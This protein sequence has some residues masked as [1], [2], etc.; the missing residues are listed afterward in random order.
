MNGSRRILLALALPLLAS[1]AWFAMPKSD[2]RAE[3][4]GGLDVVMVSPRGDTEALHS[5][6]VVFS[7]TMIPLGGR[8]RGHDN[9]PLSIT[10]AVPGSFSW[11]GSRALS[12]IPQ[13]T[14]P[15]GTRLLCRIP[16]GTRSL[17]GKA[18]AADYAWEIIV[19]R[20]R[21]LRSV[22]GDKGLT[23][24]D[25]PLYLLFNA[26]P[27]PSAIDSVR[28]TGA[29]GPIPLRLIAPDSLA[30]A[31]LLPIGERREGAAR[32]LALAPASK[33]P[34]GQKFRLEIG[35]GIPFVTSDAPMRAPVTIGYETYGAPAPRSISADLSGFAIELAG[36][37]DPDALRGK[38]SFDP[39]V[40]ISHIRP[41]DATTFRIDADLQPGTDYA[42]RFSAGLTSLLGET[43]TE[44]AVVGVRTPHRPPSLSLVPSEGYVP[45]DPAP[46]IRIAATNVDSV[47]VWGAWVDPDSVPNRLTD[48]RRI[49]GHPKLPRIA[50]WLEPRQTP[51]SARAIHLTLPRFGAPP[52]GGQV[53]QI[54]VRAR[55]LFPSP[56]DERRLLT[57][58]ALIQITDLGLST[59]TGN[60]RSLAWVTSLS[61]GQPIASA[62]VLLL[63]PGVRSALWRGKTGADGLVWLPGLSELPLAP[64][65]PL[66]AEVRTAKDAAWLDLPTYG[67]DRGPA[68]S[69]S[70]SSRHRAFVFTD[71]PLYRPTEVVHWTAHVRAIGREGIKAADIASVNYSITGPSGQSLDKG[72][73][74]LVPPGLGTGSFAI[75]AGAPL[76][77]YSIEFYR[78]EGDDAV[79]L[80]GGTFNVQEFRL[81]RFEARLNTPQSRALSG[82]TVMIEGRFAYLGGGPLA[83]A[84][85]RW[86][87]SRHPDWTRPEGYWDF[88]F[89]D[90]RPSGME[91]RFEPDGTT[92]VASGEGSLDAEGRIRLPVTP[93]L[94]SLSED[95]VYLLEMGARDVADRSAYDVVSFHAQ[96]AAY[97]LGARSR[98]SPQRQRP[99]PGMSE[100]I[101]LTAAVFDSTDS[102][103][104]GVPIRW[105]IEK[106]DWMTVRVRRIGGVFGYENVPRDSLLATGTTL[107][108]AEPSPFLW[109][110][111]AA[112]SYAFTVETTDSQGRTTRARDIVYVSG[113]QSAAW[114]REDSGWIELKPDKAEYAPGDTARILI[115]AP[116]VPTEGLVL[117]LDDG[118]RSAARLSGIE[119]SPRIGVPLPGFYPPG[120]IVQTILIG[121]TLL[122]QGPDGRQR[123]PYHGWGSASLGLRLDDWRLGVNVAADRSAYE[124]GDSVRV[125]VQVRDARGN[126]AEGTVTLA[127][128]DD[129]V[130]ELTG[131][132]KPDPLSSFFEW[133]GPGTDYSDVRFRLR[134][135][136][137]GEKG[138]LTPGGDG[139]GSGVGLRKRFT[140]TVHWEPA[141][142]VGSDGRA[143][144]AFR[145]SDDLTRYRFRALAASGVD[146][147]GYGETTVDVRKP[148][149]I[150]TSTPRFVREGDKVE[151][152]AAIRSRLPATAEIRLRAE[153]SGARVDGKAERKLKVPPEGMA[154]AIFSLRDPGRDDIRLTLRAS[155]AGHGDAL[156]IVIP[157]DR[158]YLWDREFLSG[159]AEPLFLT[160]VEPEGDVSPDRGGLT[161]VTSPS[162]LGGLSDALAY[163]IDYPY[164]CLEQISSSLLGLV[165]AG[166]VAR[167]IGDDLPAVRQERAAKAAAAIDGIQR[168][169]E[170][171]RLQSWPSGDSPDASDYAAGYALYAATRARESGIPFPRPL[172]DRLDR[173]ADERLRQLL[174]L[175]EA[176]RQGSL[177][178]LLRDGPW[179]LWTLSEADRLLPQDSTRVRLDTAEALYARRASAP[180]ESRLVLGLAMETLS[181]R[182][183]AESLRRNWPNMA[184]NLIDDLRSHAMQRTGR[185]VW[186]RSADPLWGDGLGSGMG[187]DVRMTALFLR[188]L[189]QTN[190]SDLDL[191]G[192]VAWLLDHRQARSGGWANQHMT[193][194]TLDLLV[195]TVAA[196]EGPSSQVSVKVAVGKEFESFRFLPGRNAVSRRY[197][198]ISQ[199][200]APS[201]EMRATP[202]RVETD[203]RRVVYVSASLDTAIPAL[204]APPREEGIIV[205]RTYVSRDGRPFAGAI[206]VGEPFFAHLA[207]V[208]S[209]D[210]RTLMV[211]DPLPG[212]I[213]ALNLSFQNAPRLSMAAGPQESPDTNAEVDERAGDGSL[214]GTMGWGDRGDG[215]WIVH[216]ELRDRAVRLFAEEVRAG[217]Y[218]VYYP[219]IA[220]TAGEYRTPGARAE[221]LYSP[222]IYGVSAAQTVRIVRPR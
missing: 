75:P 21:L 143:V 129:A 216:R 84:P 53:I 130:F 17:E 11:I 158:P 98:V 142:S 186:V 57:D 180:I 208:V 132:D 195:S 173:E 135:A 169:A 151:I 174:A 32:I 13:S 42:L 152:V 64:G 117:V 111:P 56:D 59:V 165:A 78:G 93:D 100:R 86:T 29:S 39:P 27:A 44:T 112:G 91:D 140:P 144:I 194:L 10:P 62:D 24:P 22:P 187:N 106:R 157:A 51:D 28:L 131:A 69:G 153:V 16:A 154:S 179:L 147:F 159:R 171:W 217:V 139:A 184:V 109:D 116:A 207:V 121:P 205:D 145:L 76:G 115:P 164:G 55:A 94:G 133:R 52:R 221:L 54:R 89:Q 31:Q 95:Q 192:L 105:T 118:I 197:T 213:E 33:I 206:P 177:Q 155:G 175:S 25:E 82:S 210:A 20:P 176:D 8:S 215:L 122:P 150:E 126:P 209:R 102:A 191:A 83:K 47:E 138:D 6:D 103:L 196:L 148:I 204:D 211:E 128:V 188:L 40:A 60:D 38:L 46:S 110:P 72:R 104:A 15:P 127:V 120:I 81:P 125:L 92:R 7:E 65:A 172:W 9:P 124:P 212:G 79:A 107:S 146:R 168:C 114:Y 90:D 161:I 1:F 37:V 96:R 119:G 2:P 19:G 137:T 67:I 178:R 141:A 199:L 123:L 190:P 30:I 48:R 193:A 73:T 3:D 97:R 4:A 99:G 41:L 34:G 201:K 113:D 88:S 222:E 18:T 203:G 200:I 214:G 156:E 136:P 50:L 182:P 134:V 163:T 14:V 183:D 101:E 218:H 189:A 49:P 36:P 23:G 58:E 74:D 77:S 198:P 80:F 108:A 26:V 61:S 5:I 68:A 202:L 167:Q 71:R 45:R 170:S 181:G 185:H 162:L 219:V 87:L 85:V 220:A 166:E 35:A 12:F 66:V 160:T 149:M 63:L 70:D 43:L